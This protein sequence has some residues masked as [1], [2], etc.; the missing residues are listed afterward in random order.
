VLALHVGDSAEGLDAMGEAW[1]A[2]MPDVPIRWAL[3]WIVRDGEEA[4]AVE[5][6]AGRLLARGW[7]R[8]ECGGLAARHLLRRLAAEPLSLT[9]DGALYG[10]NRLACRQLADLGFEGVVAPTEADAAVLA[11]LAVLASPRLIVPVYQRP[12]LF[13]SETRPV[14]PAAGRAERFELL[15]R[16][17]RRFEVAGEDGRWITRATEP[18]LRLE[19]LSA[20]RAA[21]LT[22]ARVDLTGESPGALA[23][24]WARLRPY[25]VSTP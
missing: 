5:A 8:W 12:P 24:L 10:L 25:L 11:K 20:L 7:R 19:P 16:R 17:G 22:E 4:R 2:A 3:P 9:A 23:A 13:I 18:L 1:Q 21:G 14:V 15:D 6:A